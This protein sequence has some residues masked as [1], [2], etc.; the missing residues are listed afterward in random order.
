MAY[1]GIKVQGPLEAWDVDAFGIP[2][3]IPS[4]LE[5][6]EV[7]WMEVP[8]AILKASPPPDRV[9]EM[10]FGN[11]DEQEGIIYSAEYGATVS[12]RYHPA[13]FADGDYGYDPGTWTMWQGWNS[14][15]TAAYYLSAV[16]TNLPPIGTSS[17]LQVAG[18]LDYTQ[19]WALTYDADVAYKS[20]NV[21]PGLF[22]D[23][24]AYYST[25][26]LNTT[27]ADNYY[28]AT[29]AESIISADWKFV[30]ANESDSQ[31]PPSAYAGI[32]EWLK[33]PAA[34]ENRRQTYF[35][36]P[37]YG[38]EALAYDFTDSKY[39]GDS[40]SD[41]EPL[42]AN[43]ALHSAD[44]FAAIPDGWELYSDVSQGPSMLPGAP[45]D[46]VYEV[47][48]L[49]D[50]FIRRVWAS[51]YHAKYTS[52]DPVTYPSISGTDITG[53]LY[54]QTYEEQAGSSNYA[55]WGMTNADEL[56]GISERVSDACDI[57]GPELEVIEYPKRLINSIQ[58]RKPIPNNLV[59]AFGYVPEDMYDASAAA[60]V[61]G[62]DYSDEDDGAF[63][64]PGTEMT[65]SASATATAEHYADQG[66]VRG[67]REAGTWVVGDNGIVTWD[68]SAEPETDDDK[69]IC[70]ELF[71]QGLMDAKIYKA[72]EQ[73]GAL[74]RQR[75][76]AAI[77]GYQV[78][79]RP[80]VKM[81][82]GSKFIT[83]L[84]RIIADPWSKEMA[85]QMGA[86]EEGNI[87]GKA[88]MAIGVPFCRLIG[89]LFTKQPQE[90]RAKGRAY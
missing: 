74:L 76:L 41:L 60:E 55:D 80:V 47:Q 20:K 75:D 83:Q 36:A 63:I 78:W 18:F 3:E 70:S 51:L 30:T 61:L 8:S 68:S 6:L 72:D 23:A 13:D 49:Y 12:G 71:R 19:P 14:S 38:I 16:I 43:E 82:Q 27:T 50:S 2:P 45:E 65:G 31:W 54:P 79:A 34:P 59:S 10:V 35:S 87:I 29:T 84:V 52:S 77:E 33:G 69:I 53:H 81:M 89:K 88:M 25:I 42:S 4:L 57:I 62:G 58:K 56:L 40:T 44:L 15:V 86:T 64:V 73:F 39:Y 85:Y 21:D 28:A 1:N 90:T 67:T 37:S 5:G 17:A 48:F 32:N 11:L 26:E 66:I 24:S 22:A 7:R 46:D 9:L